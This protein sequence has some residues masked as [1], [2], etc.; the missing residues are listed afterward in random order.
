MGLFTD[1]NIKI[2]G[3]A[4]TKDPKLNAIITPCYPQ[5]NKASIET[6]ACNAQ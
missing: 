5:R 3:T 1:F 4:A 2:M 6:N